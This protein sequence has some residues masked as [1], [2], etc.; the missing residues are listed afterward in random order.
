MNYL[1]QELLLYYHL[2]EEKYDNYKMNNIKNNHY[3][4]D[5]NKLTLMIISK[6]SAL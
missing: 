3:I 6:L 1:N 2:D 4:R 5:E